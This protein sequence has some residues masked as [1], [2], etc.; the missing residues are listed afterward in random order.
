MEAS[1]KRYYFFLFLKLYTVKTQIIKLWVLPKGKFKKTPLVDKN[2]V[3]C[4][5]FSLCLL[6]AD[7]CNFV[8]EIR[9][10]LAKKTFLTLNVF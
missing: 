7:G 2:S 8:A 6:S 10:H 9:I 5:A 3:R 4:W 1:K